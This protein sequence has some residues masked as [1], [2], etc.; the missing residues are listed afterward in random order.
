MENPLIRALA[1]GVL[2]LIETYILWFFF[3][4]FLH[5][6][7]EK[8]PFVLLGKGV[9]FVFQC[10]T[11]FLDFPL[12][13]SAIPTY[14]L[15]IGMSLVFYRDDLSFKALTAHIFVFL[16]YSCR[17]FALALSLQLSGTPTLSSHTFP[18]LPSYV[19]AI[20]CGLAILG[21]WG[22][23]A[24]QN[25]RR[26]DK[27]V[28]YETLFA[29]APAVF[30][31][32]LIILFRLELTG[33]R[34][35][36][37]YYWGSA[38]CL[39][40]VTLILFYHLDKMSIIHENRLHNQLAQS[41]LEEDKKRFADLVSQQKETLRIKHDIRQHMM[42]LQFLFSENKVED[43]RR[44]L[45]QV[46]AQK[47][48]TN[49]LFTTGNSVLDSLLSQK[50]PRIKAQGIKVDLNLMIP[51]NIQIEDMDLCVLLSNLLINAEEA[52]LR[53]MESP[54]GLKREAQ[55]KL[56][57][58]MKK[59]FLSI[60]ISNVYDGKVAFENR[61]YKSVKTNVAHSGIGLSNVE[62]IVDKYDGVMDISHED[63]TFRVNILLPV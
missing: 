24:F 1:F 44:Y 61:R 46:L 21:T 60:D 4:T 26:R 45:D 54:A 63:N 52:S 49:Q 59:S 40:V 9:Y 12:F 13:S 23:R 55:M 15:A 58:V 47:A 22:L 36:M 56:D 18:V 33:D 43:A 20:A 32:S 27:H 31:V 7:P 25:L 42:T 6:R 39:T 51:P 11:Y 19:Q 48:L 14:L 29:I 16:F 28:L 3:D 50:I 53:L 17:T 35:S 38:V 41:L 2:S 30:L 57:V 5:R 8:E 62:S 34:T 10:L 37:S